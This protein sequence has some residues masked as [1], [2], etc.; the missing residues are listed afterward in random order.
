MLC[1][2]TN[3]S[4][5]PAPLLGCRCRSRPA[6]RTHDKVWQWTTFSFIF[7]P[8]SLPWDRSQPKP[9]LVR[10]PRL[11]P[12]FAPKPLPVRSPRLLPCFAPKPLPVRS[13]RLLPGFYFP[14]GVAPVYIRIQCPIIL[15]LPWDRSQPKPPLVRSPRLLPCFAPKPLPVRSPR[16]LPGFYFPPGVAPVYIRIQCPIILKPHDR[17]MR[18]LGNVVAPNTW[19]L[20]PLQIP[21]KPSVLGEKREIGWELGTGQ[22]SAKG[23]AA[24]ADARTPLA[25]LPP[26]AFSTRDLAPKEV[27]PIF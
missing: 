23:P 27:E 4:S 16:L 12:C 9:P 5:R 6:G 22:R 10:S 1:T 19:P 21:L 3:P 24:P 20:V 25:F 11:L 14:P 26:K 13:P 7:S 17:Y 18:R 2:K 8:Y 15:N